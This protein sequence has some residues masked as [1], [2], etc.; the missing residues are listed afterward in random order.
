MVLSMVKGVS[1]GLVNHGM[2]EGGTCC[3]KSNN[4]LSVK[5][6][7]M[8]L[9]ASMKHGTTSRRRTLIKLT[10]RESLRPSCCVWL[11][12]QL[13][14]NWKDTAGRGVRGIWKL[15]AH[16]VR[17]RGLITSSDRA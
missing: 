15:K 13:G 17:G 4:L 6:V 11:W 16:K 7:Q 3:R 14:E 9:T 1:Q 5:T 12:G 2:G 10:E 8:G